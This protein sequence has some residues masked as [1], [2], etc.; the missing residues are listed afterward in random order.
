[1]LDEE[2]EHGLDARAASLRSSPTPQ[3]MGV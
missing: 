1:M 2:I 3:L